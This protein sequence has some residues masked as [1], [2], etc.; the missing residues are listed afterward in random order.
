M[1]MC[2]ISILY[3]GDSISLCHKTKTHIYTQKWYIFILLSIC[4]QTKASIMGLK[5]ET[6]IIV[7]YMTQRKI[8]AVKQR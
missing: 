3:F 8:C 2:I 7:R 4:Y 5:N 1:P 6:E